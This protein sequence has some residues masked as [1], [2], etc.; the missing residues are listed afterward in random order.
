MI[1][2]HNAYERA[3]HKK[4]LKNFWI[5]FNGRGKHYRHIEWWIGCM[6]LAPMKAAKQAKSLLKDFIHIVVLD[7][8]ILV[9][10]GNRLWDMIDSPDKENQYIALSVLQKYYPRA[11]T[12]EKII[13]H[14]LQKRT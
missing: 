1:K 9:E 7:K 13:R 10:E 3:Y 14:E 2:I 4:R 6:D 5:R 12:K 11:F 8:K